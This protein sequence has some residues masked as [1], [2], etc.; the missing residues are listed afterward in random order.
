MVGPGRKESENLCFIQ[1]LFI[2]IQR[3]ITVLLFRICPAASVPAKLSGK[4][5]R[6]HVKLPEGILLKLDKYASEN[7]ET[8]SGLIAQA[9]LEYITSHESIAE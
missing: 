5:R 7:G 4:A 9:A 2:K 3:V 8:R 1:L 6:V